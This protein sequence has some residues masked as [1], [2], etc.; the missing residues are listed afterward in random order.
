MKLQYF[1]RALKQYRKGSEV[2][3]STLWGDMVAQSEQE[4]SDWFGEFEA[5]TDSIEVLYD[6]E[7]GMGLYA[8][9]ED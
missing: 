1:K 9:I 8:T 7:Y 2:T 4:I 6:N 3:L 5:E